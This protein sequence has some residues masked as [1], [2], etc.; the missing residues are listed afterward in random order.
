MEKEINLDDIS[1]FSSLAALTE[2]YIVDQN[3]ETETGPLV[4]VSCRISQDAAD[5]LNSL[6]SEFGLSKSALAAELLS[7]AILEVLEHRQEFVKGT[8]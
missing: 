8:K 2:H 5:I 7:T 4:G 3:L 6:A 1:P